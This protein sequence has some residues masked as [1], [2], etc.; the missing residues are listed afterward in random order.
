MQSNERLEPS[1]TR[2]PRPVDESSSAILIGSEL[3]HRVADVMMCF[4]SD[5]KLLE[6][7][8]GAV[9]LLADLGIGSADSWCLLP[10]EVRHLCE[11]SLR[12]MEIRSCE[13]ALG[14][15]WLSLTIAP[16]G[17]NGQ[18]GGVLVLGRHSTLESLSLRLF[19][20]LAELSQE[21][22]PTE[23]K[24]CHLVRGGCLVKEIAASLHISENT[25]KFHVKNV[26]RKLGVSGGG[27]SLRQ[28]LAGLNY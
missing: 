16:F 12:T 24:I 14:Q 5:G 18:P 7:N 23:A 17:Q 6:S 22:T 2:Q 8:A 25:V 15:I 3:L 21:I 4:S 10:Q 27:S 26:R 19:A 28:V 11:Q 20:R 1:L 13:A 9:K